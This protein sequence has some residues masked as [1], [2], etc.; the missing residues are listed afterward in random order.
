M[1]NVV[2]Y[3]AYIENNKRLTWRYVA[4]ELS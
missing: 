1:L 3:I 4:L 2:R